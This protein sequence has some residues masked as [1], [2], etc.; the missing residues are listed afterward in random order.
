[1]NIAK[2]ALLS[3][4]SVYKKVNKRVCYCVNVYYVTKGLT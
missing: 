1:M 3:W 2:Q 4:S